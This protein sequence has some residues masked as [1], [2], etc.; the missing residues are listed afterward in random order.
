[1]VDQTEMLQRHQ[2][3]AKNLTNPQRPMT[4]LVIG[5][6]HEAEIGS[7]MTQPRETQGPEVHVLTR[8]SSGHP[9]VVE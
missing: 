3:L 7:R 5:P 9:G 2:E 6:S 8:C 4:N 1:M